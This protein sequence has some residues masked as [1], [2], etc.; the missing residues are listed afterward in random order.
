MG[1]TVALIMAFLAILVTRVSSFSASVTKGTIIG[2]GRIGGLLHELNGGVDQLITRN[3]HEKIS[4]GVEGP[5]YVCTR[6]NDL[7]AI[8]EACP[9]DRRDDLIF[10]QNGILSEYLKSKNL[11]ENTQGLV[12]FA[13][14]KK[15]EPPIDGK[16]DT[17]PEGLT[18]VTGK[19]GADMAARLA[20]A[21]LACKVLDKET[22][23]VAMM[24]KHIWICAF[25][26]I[27]SQYEGCT[28]GDVEKDHNAEVRVLISELAAAASWESGLTFTDNVGDRLCAYARSVAHFP[29]A[30][31]EFE[32]RN[33][34]FA[35]ITL[36]RASRLMTDLSPH[37][38]SILSNNPNKLFFKAKKSYVE[39]LKVEALTIAPEWYAGKDAAEVAAGERALERLLNKPIIKA[40]SSASFTRSP[41]ILQND[42]NS[43]RMLKF[44][45]YKKEFEELEK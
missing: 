1:Y 40:G 36:K 8:I 33:G 31:K 10:L 28:V 5:I 22:W 30:L 27:G 41:T 3:S 19:W 18:A 38:T 9:K 23:N 34:W 29:T 35:D 13:V 6:N 25:M 39:R 16:T 2:G 42:Q 24:E 11:E 12:Y 32:W 21:N 37:H 43:A 15:G 17:N 26:A 14:S 44:L 20:K 4:S 45:E 7:E